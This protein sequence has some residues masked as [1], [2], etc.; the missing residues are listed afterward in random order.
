MECAVMVAEAAAVVAAVAIAMALD[1]AG[2]RPRSADQWTGHERALVP[3]PEH[4]L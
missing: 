4:Q 1:A 2:W 3:H